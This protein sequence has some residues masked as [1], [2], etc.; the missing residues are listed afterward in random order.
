M[1]AYRS[2]LLNTH[3]ITDH[4][5]KLLKLGLKTSQPVTEILRETKTKVKNTKLPVLLRTSTG[6]VPKLKMY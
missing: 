4:I 1:R 3:M 5:L 2:L 6:F